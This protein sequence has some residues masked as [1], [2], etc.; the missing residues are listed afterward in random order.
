MPSNLPQFTLR[1]S[2]ILLKKLRYI[3]E[4]NAR[5]ANR[6]VELLIQKHVRSFEKEH[7][8]IHLKD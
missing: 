7:G 5:S 1:I 4:Y 2:L 6:E 3:A 8:E